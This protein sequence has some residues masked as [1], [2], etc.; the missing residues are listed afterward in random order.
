M[1][2]FSHMAALAWQPAPPLRAPFLLARARGHPGSSPTT[3]DIGVTR[4]T[5]QHRLSVA[6][7]SCRLPLVFLGG[8]L[9]VKGGSRQAR[10][11]AALAQRRAE[12]SWAERNGFKK[13][14][15]ENFG[16]QQDPEV[17]LKGRKEVIKSEPTQAQAE[18]GRY[19]RVN[20][21]A[22]ATALDELP[23]YNTPLK[24][25]A[26]EAREE[27]RN[28]KIEELPWFERIKIRRT[29]EEEEKL[30][31]LKTDFGKAD[32]DSFDD[33]WG[34]SDYKKIEPALS[35]R[36][37]DPNIGAPTAHD[38]EGSVLLKA[39]PDLKL[40]AKDTT[41]KST[42]ADFGLEKDFVEKLLDMSEVE[43]ADL[44][45]DLTRKGFVL[46]EAGE[47]EEAKALLDRATKIGVALQ[48][49][50]EDKHGVPRRKDKAAEQQE[51][52]VLAKMQRELVRDDFLM[53][54]GK[55]ARG[56]RA[57]GSF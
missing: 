44:I 1:V 48:S 29:A 34:R 19:R 2:D 43:R 13:L 39:V 25:R 57:I 55:D 51:G 3:A 54:F 47:L 30:Q 6:V 52:E 53:I 27:S 38:L 28:K 50:H 33:S 24:L 36:A 35:G 9:A 56:A 4:Q 16:P 5:E 14:T 18:T 32:K 37:A 8:G 22:A 40:K 17:K 41:A 26:R 21:D 10:A 12:K 42:E 31:R 15:L 20:P 7:L 23:E 45:D 49:L 46:L 11:K